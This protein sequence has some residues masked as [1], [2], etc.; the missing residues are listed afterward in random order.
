M[1]D[2]SLSCL[3]TRSQLGLADLELNDHDN[4][5]LASD[6]LTGAQSWNRQQIT[7]PFTD[8]SVTTYRTMQVVTRQLTVEVLTGG[9]ETT[10]ALLANLGALINA[11]GQDSFHIKVT[12]DGQQLVY[13]AEAADYTLQWDGPRTIAKQ[14]QVQAQVPCQPIPLAGAV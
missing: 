10:T 8:G 14:L 5:Y 12:V 9:A 4:Y 3:L 2:L 1:P 11:L 7:S 13:Q 6:F